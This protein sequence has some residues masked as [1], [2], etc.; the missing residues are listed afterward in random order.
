MK[1][2]LIAVALLA[3]TVGQAHANDGG[4][5]PAAPVVALDEAVTAGKEK[6]LIRV[7]AWGGISMM[8]GGAAVLGTNN[9]WIGS[10]EL[11]WFAAQNLAW[12]LI[13]VGIAGVGALVGDEKAE[14]LPGVIE[15]EQ[16]WANILWVNEGLDAGY[17]MVGGTLLG[18]GL[19]GPTHNPLL[20]GTGA[21]IILQGLGL[22]LLDG[23]AL[24]ESADR[25]SA[26]L[27]EV[28]QEKP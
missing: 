19:M 26:Q 24:V 15:K 13:N 9:L 23:W 14:D 20:V 3:T 7:A 25:Q 6:H 2:L 8:L 22:A 11:K 21:G 28:P 10:D 27:A 17:M 12:G 5:T 16:W 1:S 18:F 4:P